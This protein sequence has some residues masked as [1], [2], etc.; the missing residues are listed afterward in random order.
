MEMKS[1]QY[2]V[3][4]TTGAVLDFSDKPT[5]NTVTKHIGHVLFNA[6]SLVG[7]TM[8]LVDDM[9]I[10]NGLPFNPKATEVVRNVYRSKGHEYP[11][12]IHGDVVIVNDRD[13]EREPF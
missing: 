2:R 4:T 8:M 11:Y 7:D 6:V 13:F 10:A 12:L 3:I 5:L 1:G 9:G